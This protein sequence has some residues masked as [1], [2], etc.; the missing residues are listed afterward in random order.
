MANE[1][2]QFLG[3]QKLVKATSYTTME[4]QQMVNVQLKTRHVIM[5][6]NKYTANSWKILLNSGKSWIVF[7][8]ADAKQNIDWK[9]DG[10]NVLQL[11][12]SNAKGFTSV[13]R[14]TAVPDLIAESSHAGKIPL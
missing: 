2:D 9:L 3:T 4:F 10:I 8:I 5:Q 6:F 12:S 11:K 7:V 13:I 14:V 1:T